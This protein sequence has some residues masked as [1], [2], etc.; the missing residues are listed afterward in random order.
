MATTQSVWR[1][2]LQKYELRISNITI[3]ELSATRNKKD[4]KKLLKLI[5][6]IKMIVANENCLSLAEEY[7]KVISIPDND[8]LHAAIA[9]VYNCDILLSWNFVHLVN[10]QNRIKINGT[11]LINGY[12]ELN[13]ISPYELGG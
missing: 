5:K 13:I 6:N 7:L 9:S 10:Y 3:R 12:K 2:E 8:T 4:R 1:N 11:N